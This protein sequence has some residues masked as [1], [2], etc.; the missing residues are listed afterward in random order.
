MEGVSVWDIREQ[1]QYD[2]LAAQYGP[3]LVDEV[4]ALLQGVLD[5][6]G[7]TL[8]INGTRL[9]VHVVRDRLAG[10]EYQHVDAVLSNLS[11]LTDVRNPHAYLRSMLYNAPACTQLRDQ[12]FVQRDFPAP[13]PEKASGAAPTWGR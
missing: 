1:I 8:T 7:G 4:V 9:P 13:A 2:A 6:Q 5:A 11:H 3:E 12:A 10:L